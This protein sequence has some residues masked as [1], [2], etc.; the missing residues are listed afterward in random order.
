MVTVLGTAALGGAAWWV[1]LAEEPVPAAEKAYGD[2]PR[3]DYEQW[4][5]DLGYTE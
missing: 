3:S 2:I 4:L 5:Q 1:W